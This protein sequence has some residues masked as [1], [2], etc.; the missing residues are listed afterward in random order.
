MAT[1]TT[2]TQKD[3]LQK[4]RDEGKASL[5]VQAEDGQLNP[6]AFTKYDETVRPYGAETDRIAALL[7]DFL[8]EFH[9]KNGKYTWELGFYLEGAKQTRGVGGWQVLTRAALGPLWTVEIQRQAGLHIHDGAMCWAGRG[10]FERHIICV[11]TTELRERQEAAK[12]ARIQSMLRQ[13]DS[14]VGQDAELTVD[15]K[16]RHI[17][18]NPQ[19]ESGTEDGA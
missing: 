13:P 15:E 5:Q 16:V 1:K 2:T 8:N 17:P 6:E 14:V 12:E 19:N 9:S 4:M 3:R 11:K 10:M 18:L 7:L